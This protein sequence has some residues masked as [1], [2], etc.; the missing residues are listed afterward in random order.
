MTEKERKQELAA[1][2]AMPDDQIDPSD[3]PEIKNRT[4]GVRGRFF[5]GET[6]MISI[7]L[8][9]TD[10]QTA[11]R[12]AGAKGIPYQTFIKSLLHDALERE[13]KRR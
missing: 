6:R 5:R 12:L 9:E 11:N 2:A 4:G 3:I 8:D 13:A 7:R 10:L 1:L